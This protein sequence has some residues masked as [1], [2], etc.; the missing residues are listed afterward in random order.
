VG[1]GPHLGAW[2]SRL[3]EQITT[4]IDLVLPGIPG[5]GGT[6]HASFI[7]F[8]APAFNLSSIDWSYGVHTWHT[9]RDTYDKV[10][11]EEIRNNA[12]LTAMLV[13]LAS[14]D[15][16]RVSRERR[17]MPPGPQGQQRQW[18]TCSPGRAAP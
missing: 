18:P 3:P 5:A 17:Q 13:Y 1:A 11:M 7:C 8:G 6:D 16:A 14:E 2:L 9:N 12:V 10:V 15:P 4:H